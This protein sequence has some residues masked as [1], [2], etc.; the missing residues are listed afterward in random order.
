MAQHPLEDYPGRFALANELHARPF[1]ELTAPCRAAHI[2]I[3]AEHNAAERD[4]SLDL[5]HL[6]A[7]LDRF[8]APHPPPDANHYSG[9]LGRGYLKWEQHTEFVTY[10]ILADGVA[11]IPF[12]GSIRAMFPTDWLA[13]SPGKLLTSCIVRAERMDASADV[14]AF[15]TAHFPK[16]FVPE[17]LAVSKVID[18]AATIASDFRI[19]EQGHVRFAVLAASDTGSRRL[20]RIVQRCLEIETYKA[21]AML[22]L[23][24]ARDVARKTAAFDRELSE[25][26]THM[27]S[28][29]GDEV[30]TL[31]RLLKTSAEIELLSSSTAF[32]FGAAG[33]Y[34]A[35][36]GQRIEVLREERL[37]SRQTFAEFMMRRFE[38]AMRTCRSAEGRLTELSTR[39]ARASNLLRTRV[40][41]ASNAQNN[42][43]LASMNE[44]A[45]LQLR[46]QETVEGLSVVAISYY[47]VNLA[48]NIIIPLAGSA[49]IGP[50]WVYAALTPLVVALVFLAVRRIR[51]K[52]SNT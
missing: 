38:P 12:D 34:S 18:G 22:T 45:A 30:E 41:V 28:N 14:N 9:K 31:D 11:D 19:D 13:E 8:G 1:P 4:R 35:I 49:G 21:A 3:K 2:A 48:A 39:A 16:W 10:T 37:A 15:V 40:D 20:G 5:A 29:S 44:R 17:S 26:V 50:G 47:A 7:L 32:R 46:L 24:I 33:A 6:V 42:E 52:I 51:K 36:S 23:P 25:I 27:A 43:I